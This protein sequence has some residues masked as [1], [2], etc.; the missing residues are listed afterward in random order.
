MSESYTKWKGKRISKAKPSA[1]SIQL[2]DEAREI[3]EKHRQLKQDFLDREKKRTR[4][5]A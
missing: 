2:A 3:A 4:E 1:R 5:S